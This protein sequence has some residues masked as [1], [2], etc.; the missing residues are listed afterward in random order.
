MHTRGT[1]DHTCTVSVTVRFAK[2]GIITIYKGGGERAREEG[3]T[4]L[5]I[6]PQ[7]SITMFHQSRSF[8]FII[9]VRGVR[10]LL[11]RPPRD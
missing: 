11:S 6:P 7:Y 4:F 3:G 2:R 8:F 5:L 9:P 10:N 1:P